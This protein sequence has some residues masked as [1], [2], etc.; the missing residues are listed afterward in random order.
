MIPGMNPK[1]MQQAMKKMGIKQ[2][3]IDA[4]EVI[5]KTPSKTIVILNPQVSKIDMMGQ[6]TYQI[7][8]EE[9][10]QAIKPLISEEDIKMVSEQAGVDETKA[11]EALE[12]SDGDLAKAITELKE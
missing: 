2:V 5:I 7:S 3:D 8:G 6:Q 12:G 1:Q 11:K 4:T 10:E 9:S